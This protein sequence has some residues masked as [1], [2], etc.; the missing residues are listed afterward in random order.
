MPQVLSSHLTQNLDRGV[1]RLLAMW[2][3]VKHDLENSFVVLEAPTIAEQQQ[4]EQ[5]DEESVDKDNQT[6]KR[7]EQLVSLADFK[8]NYTIFFQFVICSS[9]CISSLSPT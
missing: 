8:V 7:G 4:K 2:V 5:S 3:Y 6:T 9:P 1:R